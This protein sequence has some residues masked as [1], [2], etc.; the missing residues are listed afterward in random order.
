MGLPAHPSSVSST[1]LPSRS[2]TTIPSLIKPSSLYDLKA[3]DTSATNSNSQDG[4]P[5]HRDSLALV[6]DNRAELERLVEKINQDLTSAQIAAAS[7]SPIDEAKERSSIQSFISSSGMIHTPSESQTALV[8]EAAG[9]VSDDETL[10]LILSAE[11]KDTPV[12]DLDNEAEDQAAKTMTSENNNDQHDSEPDGI[13]GDSTLISSIT[14]E[15]AGLT[16]N[17]FLDCASVDR[18]HHSSSTSTVKA[19]QSDSHTEPGVY[20]SS[21]THPPYHIRPCPPL[22][23]SLC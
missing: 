5:T 4:R 1:F 19:R 12:T 20:I 22:S 14:V 10:A 6:E 15:P 3:A 23:L 16:L 18:K 13:N 2:L 11:V 7:Q 9:A 21:S 17:D 8:K